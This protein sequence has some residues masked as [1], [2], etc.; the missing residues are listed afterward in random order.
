M[1]SHRRRTC[2]W[3]SCT[4]AGHLIDLDTCK[5]YCLGCALA[6]L[7]AADDPIVNFREL[8]GSTEYADALTRHPILGVTE[9]WPDR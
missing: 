8:N 4:A 5:S 1:G 9:P 7:R 2:T 3:Q 6:M